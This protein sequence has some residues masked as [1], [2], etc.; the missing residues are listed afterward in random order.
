MDAANKIDLGGVLLCQVVWLFAITRR[1]A[2]ATV[3]FPRRWTVDEQ[4]KA[5]A[6][7]GSLEREISRS[8]GR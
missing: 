1:G 8:S 3:A 6:T 5:L 7:L 4:Q 2:E